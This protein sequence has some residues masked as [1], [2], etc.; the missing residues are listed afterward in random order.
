MARFYILPIKDSMEENMKRV[1]LVMM[2][3][4]L[5]V[6]LGFASGKQEAKTTAPVETKSTLTGTAAFGGS[7]TV[8]PIAYAAIEAMQ[9]ENPG[10]KISYE[11][12]G[13]STGI[14][15][16]LAGVYTLA[17]SSRDIKDTE[18][19]EGAKPV[20]IALD[21]LSAVVN[22]DINISNVTMEQLAGIFTGEIKNW[23]DVGGP[24]LPIE[25]INRDETSGTYGAFWELVCEKK[26]GKEVKYTKNAVV[27]KENG[28]VAA[29][30]AS[31]PHAIGYVGMGFVTDVKPIE[32][33]KI[34]PTRETIASG[35]Y[36]VARPLYM[37]TN[38]YPK[39]GS[40]LHAIV[41]LHLTKKGQEIIEAKDFIPVTSY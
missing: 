10:L 40:P 2:I 11:G 19:S 25:V 9:K 12:V 3:A 17:G 8:A 37:F 35:A 13:S 18:I 20:A 36:P 5:A 33:D 21:G 34:A 16:L 32:V 38:G 1:V 22:K 15:Q 4:C 30:V 6:G 39:L 7:T 31:T 23:K 27:A 29:K 41:T 24:D 14:K 28:E 26:Y